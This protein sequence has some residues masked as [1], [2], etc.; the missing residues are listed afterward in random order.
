[1]TAR[2][3]DRQRLR[4]KGRARAL[5]V[6]CALVIQARAVWQR[7]VNSLDFRYCQEPSGGCVMEKARHGGPRRGSGRPPGPAHLL[8]RNRVAV[9]VTDREL[10]KLEALAKG[11]DAPV[12]TAAHTRLRE[13]LREK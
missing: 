4:A 10:K 6:V 2:P 13:A 12:A 1:M 9:L 11:W 3:S 8:R 7:P 5:L